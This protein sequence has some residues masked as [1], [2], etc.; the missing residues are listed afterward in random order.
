MSS[1]AGSWT[2][3]GSL[4]ILI[5]HIDTVCFLVDRAASTALIESQRAGELNPGSTSGVEAENSSLSIMLCRAVALVAKMLLRRLESQVAI[6]S[7][8]AEFCCW[9]GVI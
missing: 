4:T 7:R 9:K 8:R 2:R 6:S 1:L 5:V 3:N